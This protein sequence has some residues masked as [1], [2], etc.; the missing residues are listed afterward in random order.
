MYD[1]VPYDAQAHVIELADV[2]LMSFYIADCQALA[3]I[4][5][6]L[7]HAADAR[8]LSQRATTYRQSLARLWHEPTGLYLNQ[9]TDTGEFS[10]RLSPTHFYPLLTK[11]PTLQQATRMMNHFYNPAEFWGEWILPSIA[12]N[13]PGFADN[14][15]WRGRIWA[16]MNFLVY[17]GLQH[18]DL[19]QVRQ[20]LAAKSLALLL[21]EW[22]T[23]GHVHE[24]YNALT[25]DGDDVNSSDIYYHWGALLGFMALLENG[26]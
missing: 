11:L 17:M 21:H 9:R 14:E 25:G 2:G 12:R 24:N 3:E 6:L 26:F 15:Y 7:G 22:N 5:Q 13:D 4:A 1:G 10:Q 19:P 18:Y 20:D 16:P 8:E 23:E